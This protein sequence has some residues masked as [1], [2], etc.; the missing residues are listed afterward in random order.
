MI[1]ILFYLKKSDADQD[2]LEHI[3]INSPKS[4]KKV[5]EGKLVGTYACEV[6]LS[7]PDMEKKQHLIYAENPL[8]SL[9]L[10]S[11]F[12]KS[13][14]QFL[15]NRGN[16]ISETESHEP[17]KLE[18]KDPQVYLQ[19]KVSELKNN[20][21]IPFEDRQKILGILK[22]SFGKEP[23]PI[24]DQINMLIDDKDMSRQKGN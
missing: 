13:Q 16:T 12:A 18:K 23:S 2:N 11:E 20:K 7:I 4:P 3:S 10:A 21:N 15:L 6:Y 14:L 8:H 5:L 1:K 24:K 19:E 17:W 22:D 9:C